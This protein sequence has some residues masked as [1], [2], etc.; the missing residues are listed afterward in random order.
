MGRAGPDT[1]LPIGR[2]SVTG[3]PD[4]T[5]HP[6]LRDPSGSALVTDPR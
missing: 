1:P 6:P 3:I 5:P 4:R 2:A